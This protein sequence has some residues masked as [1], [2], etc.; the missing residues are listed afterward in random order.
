MTWLQEADQKRET[1]AREEIQR[2]DDQLADLDRE[3][4]ALTRQR[5][6][7]MRFIE[8]LET[9]R[10]ALNGSLVAEKTGEGRSNPPADGL[11][12]GSS[13]RA[14]VYF[15]RD[16]FGMSNPPRGRKTDEVA[17][18]VIRLGYD[19]ELRGPALTRRVNGELWRLSKLDP[20]QFR[21]TGR[22]RYRMV[23]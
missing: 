18:H 21:R 10:R 22:G 4:D 5:D 7:Y 15:I 3:R 20:P 14:L 2:I 9:S 8:L 19:S 13:N 23:A 16:A 17:E 6:E 11:S 12:S 1:W